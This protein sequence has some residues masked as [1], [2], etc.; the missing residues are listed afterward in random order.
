MPVHQRTAYE[1]P[2][3]AALRVIMQ[4]EA[5]NPVEHEANMNIRSPQ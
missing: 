4:S 5:I 2:T 1:Q 3:P